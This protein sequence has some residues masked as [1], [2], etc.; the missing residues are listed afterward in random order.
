MI[1]NPLPAEHDHSRFKSVLLAEQITVI[2]DEMC[3]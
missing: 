1:V 3:V 2:G